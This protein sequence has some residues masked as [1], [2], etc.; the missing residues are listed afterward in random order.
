MNLDAQQG[1]YRWAEQSMVAKDK[2]SKN[3]MLRL[4]P[5]VWS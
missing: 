5:A 3:E 2:G 4:L 1:A